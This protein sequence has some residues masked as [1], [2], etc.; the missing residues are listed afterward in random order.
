[1]PPAYLP[2]CWQVSSWGIHTE[3]SVGA[4]SGLKAI[5]EK[6]GKAGA[7]AV[8]PASKW[9]ETALMLACDKGAAGKVKLLLAAGANVAAVDKRG[10]TALHAAAC[11]GSADCV[12][13][14]L[15]AKADPKAKDKDKVSAGAYAKAKGFADCSVLL[16]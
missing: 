7:D 8:D 9:G 5:L 3:T 13:L 16:K 6:A 11:A 4:S 12:K 2:A 10:R 1:M 15:D 14:L